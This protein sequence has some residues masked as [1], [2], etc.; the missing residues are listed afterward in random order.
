MIAIIGDNLDEGLETVLVKLTGSE[1][2]EAVIAII[3]DGN[4]LV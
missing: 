4:N 1:V 2:D 3:D